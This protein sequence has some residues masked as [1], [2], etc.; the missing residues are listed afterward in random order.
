ML[1]LPKD[2]LLVILSEL[3]IKCYSNLS[4]VN[5][6]MNNLVGDEQLWKYVCEKNEIIVKNSKYLD[7]AKNIINRYWTWDY[8]TMDVK[9]DKNKITNYGDNC[10][11]MSVS[12][13]FCEKHNEF[14]IRVLNNFDLQAELAIVDRPFS[15][16]K[17]EILQIN[18]VAKIHLDYEKI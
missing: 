9:I 10:W 5:R 12:Q 4:H 7:A 16:C 3:P 11:M 13:Y 15:M 17:R 8:R 2:I 6:F 18:G 1:N 14:S